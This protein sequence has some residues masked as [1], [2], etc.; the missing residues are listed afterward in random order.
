VELRC[1]VVSQDRAWS[2]RQ[3]RRGLR[4]SWR[5]IGVADGVDAAMDPVEPA[6]AHAMGDR[7]APEPPLELPPRH[8]AVLPSG[9]RR[10]PPVDVQNIDGGA[11]R[12]VLSTFCITTVHKVKRVAG[13]SGVSTLGAAEGGTRTPSSHSLTVGVDATPK[14]RRSDT[15]A[16]AVGSPASMSSNDTLTVAVLG[17]GIMGAA[18]ARNIAG[19]GHEVRAWNRT[20]KKAEPLADDGITVADTA[21]EAVDGADVVVTMLA[22]GDAVKAVAEEAIDGSAVWAQM[23][24]VGLDAARELADV[25]KEKGASYVDAPVLGTKR[26]AEEGKLIVLASGD[27]QARQTAKPI[28]DAVGAKT[29]DLGDDAVAG[30]RLKVVLNSWI[31]GLV[32]ALAETIKVAEALGVDPQQFLD[33]IEGGPLD[34]GYAHVKGGAM[35]SREFPTSFALELARKDV[36]LVLKAA[37][38]AGISLPAAAATAQSLD[39]AIEDGHG[40]EDL[41]AAYLAL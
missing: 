21:P 2:D 9:E 6:G 16:R 28:F 7:P 18:M 3:E 10:H 39:K 13:T 12:R 38:D 30:S 17:T 29:V 27:G 14:A 26:P 31:V 4:A 19:A 25:A 36:G 1:G 20:R 37:E 15:P 33:T 41:A 24:T 22:A 8:H 32:Q 5:K 34:A 35:I 23:S 40:G 11:S